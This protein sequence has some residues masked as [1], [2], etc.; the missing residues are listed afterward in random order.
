MIF[1]RTGTVKV[2]SFTAK[3]PSGDK[4]AI[5][6]DANGKIAVEVQVPSSRN[7]FKTLW[8]ESYETHALAWLRASV[9][10]QLTSGNQVGADSLLT[11]EAF[12]E[13][14]AIFFH[15]VVGKKPAP[16]TVS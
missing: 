10:I 1:G 11:Q 5:Y 6:E 13:E 7:N 16:T 8:V 2:H 4:L 9:L 3:L 12:E 14:A 15:K